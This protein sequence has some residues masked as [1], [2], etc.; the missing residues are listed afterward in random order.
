MYNLLDEVSM[1]NIVKICKIH[2]EL[3][4]PETIINR[5]S[6]TGK[7][8]LRCKVCRNDSERNRINRTRYVPARIK[9]PIPEHVNDDSKYH[10]Y[11][12]KNRFKITAIEYYELLT[13]QEGNCAICKKPEEITKLKSNKPK[14]LAVDHCH[15]SGKIRGLLCQKCNTALGSFKDSIEMLESAIIYLNASIL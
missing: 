13:K 4:K 6:P 15:S 2:G 3:S 12:I 11:M 5:L 14:M 7:E 8:Y 10:A 9:N 1:S